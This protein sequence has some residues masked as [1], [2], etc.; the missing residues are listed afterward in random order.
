M[1]I[2]ALWSA[3]RTYFLLSILSVSA[4]AAT[5]PLD[6]D[7]GEPDSA[8]TSK[9]LHMLKK[10]PPREFPYGQTMLEGENPIGMRCLTTPRNKSYVGVEQWM[11]IRAPMSRVKALLDDFDN[12]EKLFIGFDD[13]HVLKKDENKFVLQWKQHVP[14][15]PDI[16]YEMDYLVSAMPSGNVVYRYK[17]H[18]GRTIKHSDG[19]IVLEPISRD[20]TRYTEYDFFEANWGV[21]ALSQER[22]WKESAEGIYLSD[23]VVKLKSENPDWPYSKVQERAKKFL[24]DFPVDKVV[25]ERTSIEGL[26]EFS[27]L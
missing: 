14:V 24:K 7:L 6:T 23:A 8:Y 4:A 11:V 22:I 20:R 3:F 13:V 19:I 5:F 17:L 1:A 15:L 18:Y 10:W 26:K 25:K 9:L 16:T 2:S 27:D 12:Y 21:L